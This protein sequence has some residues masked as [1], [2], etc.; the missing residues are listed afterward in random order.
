MQ[1]T[2]RLRPYQTPGVPPVPA[3]RLAYAEI[4]RLLH[5]WNAGWFP[6]PGEPATLGARPA[7]VVR[8]VQVVPDPIASA[9]PVCTANT[10]IAVMSAHSSRTWAID[11]LT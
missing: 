1:K 3:P 11:Y 8:M 7:V 2:L 9:Q 4:T 10:L 6:S 5:R